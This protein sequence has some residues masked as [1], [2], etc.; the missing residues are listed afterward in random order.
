MVLVLHIFQGDLRKPLNH[1]GRCN[2]MINL[3]Y[4]I[5]LAVF[6][7]YASTFALAFLNLKKAEKW[8][9]LIA[10]T[11]NAAVLTLIVVSSGHLPVF[12]LFES[13]LLVIFVLGGLGIFCSKPEDAFPCVR[14]WIW[15]EI[16][17]LFGITFFSSKTPSFF[18]YAH[19]N[20]YVVLFHAFRIVALA[21]ALFSSAQFIQF[22]V[23]RNRD[24]PAN[25]LSNTGRNYLLLSAIFFLAGEYVGI[26]WCRNGW[27]DLWRW[28]AGFFQSTLI[29]LYLMLVFHIPGKNY[30]SESFRSLLGGMSGF[31]ML[32]LTLIRIVL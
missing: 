5:Y 16:M 21:L 26:I 2:G 28:S 31:V 20:L 29:V 8:L 14:I 23:E 9:G 13:F 7:L 3:L 27:G 10:L 30:R 18:S 1:H 4:Y 25:E 32:T 6:L 11:A 12:N 19:D 22:R 15:L 24:A 17:V